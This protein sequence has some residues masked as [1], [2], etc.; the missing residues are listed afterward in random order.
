MKGLHEPPARENSEHKNADTVRKAIDAFNRRDLD[1]FFSYHT[2][3]TTSHEVYFPKPL[4]R[5]E[6][7]SF[8]GRFLRAYPDAR[9]ETQSLVVEGDV[10]VV[11]NV[12]TATFVNDLDEVRATGRAYRA[13]EAVVFELEGGKIKAARIYLDQKSIEQQLGLA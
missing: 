13:R 1:G 5:D 9:I 6:F 7:R 10:V 2:P 4:G 8:L 11:E 12:L 3:D